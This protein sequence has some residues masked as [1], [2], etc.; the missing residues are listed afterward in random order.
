M[1]VLIGARAPKRGRILVGADTALDC[2]VP[3]ECPSK[4]VL[5]TPQD[6]ASTALGR[7]ALERFGIVEVVC[8]LN[9]DPAVALLAVERALAAMPS[10]KETRLL[11][12]TRAA[13]SWSTSLPDLVRLCSTAGARLTLGI[14]VAR[15]SASSAGLE[16]NRDAFERVRRIAELS[17]SL[18]VAAQ[19]RMPVTGFN[20]HLPPAILALAKSLHQDCLFFVPQLCAT[21]E[22][23][24]G[25]AA[26][27][28]LDA[29][30][31][32]FLADFFVSR[33]LLESAPIT[34]RGYY[35]LTAKRLAELAISSSMQVR[36][37]DKRTLH[38]SRASLQ[39]QAIV[40]AVAESHLGRLLDLAARALRFL[41]V[42]SFS[43]VEAK[44][45]RLLRPREPEQLGRRETKRA[46]IVGAYGGEHVGDAAILGG[47]LQSLSSRGI[48]HA[49]VAT[50]RPHRTQRWIRC[51]DAP[52][53]VETI[54]QAI[55]RREVA[56]CAEV[57]Y[58]GG[59]LM[60]LKNVLPQHLRCISL[61]KRMGARVVLHGIGYGPFRSQLSQ[62]IADTMLRLGDVVEARSEKTGEVLR[63]KGI[64]AG[65]IPDPSVPY[66]A[67]RVHLS[68]ITPRE[69]RSAA[70]LLDADNEFSI[71]LNLR[72]LWS[73]YVAA[74]VSTKSLEEGFIKNL[75]S[76]LSSFDQLVN[77]KLRVVFFA[78]NADQYGFS[79]LSIAESLRQELGGTID[80]RIWFE[81]PG[82][83]GVL[84]LLRKCHACV[85]MRF[86]A[87]MFALSQGIPT[88]G[89]DYAF[90]MRG[91]VSDL[92]SERGLG[93]QVVY[94]DDSAESIVSQLMA[95]PGLIERP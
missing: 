54:P 62:A 47:V 59:P 23:R 67:S 43:L 63:G 51:I 38:M 73:K 12:D 29:D 32:S 18:G 2:P 17:N 22:I 15:S 36:S 66:L 40:G 92:M 90:G 58:G 64:R 5:L 88:I 57:V 20:A 8:G 30:Q 21:E 75:S 37:G 83:D 78:M 74:Q 7:P 72:P 55:A 93:Q 3:G 41:A 80:Y 27:P 1:R 89:I 56:S 76:A 52:L 31:L 44:A 25:V 91:K 46:L 16:T 34:Q 28:W 39:Y 82:I 86:H 45:L 14:V 84:S 24:N 65:V 81:E 33:A 70:G 48:T 13:G 61:G 94:L 10:L 35:R 49:M 60:D 19:V 9:E 42:G 53:V 77:G 69:I 11:V 68:L 87:V 50:L 95:L 85:A 26:D 4:A 79:D 71:A 6:L